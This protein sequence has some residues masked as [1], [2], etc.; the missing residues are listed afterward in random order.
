[1]KKLKKIGT[2]LLVTSFALTSPCY[3]LTKN[4]TVYSK[5]NNNGSVKTTI[6]SEYLKNTDDV[7]NDETNLKNI[8]NLNG[9]EKYKLEGTSLVWD[10]KGKDI[11]YQGE[12][13]AELPVDLNISYK[14][15]NENIDLK[16][17]LGK[18]GHVAI[19]LKYINKE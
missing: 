18:K 8:L 6:V 12:T 3:A 17:L 9:N 2:V 19:T 15:S 14:L 10:A 4:E 11:Y 16:D 1:M 5:L 13:E 7:I